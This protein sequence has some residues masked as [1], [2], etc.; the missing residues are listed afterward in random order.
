MESLTDPRAATAWL[1]TP[2]AIRARCRMVYEAAEAG[3]LRHFA[4][5]A[6]R[7]GEAARY[8][9]ETIRG[10]YPALDVPYHSRWRH[11]AVDGRDRWQELQHRLTGTP[12]DELARTRFDLA[13]TSVLLDAGAGA[14]WRYR[15]PGSGALHARSEG[16]ALASLYG[17]QDGLFSTDPERRCRADADAL[18][19]LE[20]ETL[21]SAFQADSGNPLIGL[22]GRAA[23]LR[24]LGGA[25]RDRPDLFGAERPRIGV[26]FDFF[27]A[28][29]G[30][31]GLP[32]ASILD[33]LLEAL[34]PI[35]PGRLAIDGA[36]LGD[37]WRHPAAAS[38]DL[39]DRLVPFH[40]L[41][42]WLAYSLVEPLEAA[43]VTVTGLDDLTGLAEYRNGGLFLDLGVLRPKHDGVL[44]RRHAADSELVVEWRALT[45]VLLDRVAEQIRADLGLSAAELPL[46][47]VLEGGTWSAGRRIAREKRSDGRPP[48]A[49]ESDGTLF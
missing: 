47:R 13:V 30:E 9:L 16:L 32:A 38:S 31:G 12:P 34:G 49:V 36:V 44:G 37:V 10:R 15:E 8:V 28:A 48:I 40:K 33:T 6:G 29:S 45:V 22:A 26:L 2:A 14:Q 35:W 43:G 23:L 25:L 42:Q 24:R 3:A 41:S 18:E 1:R 27:K 17:F 5:D 19:Q 20:T 21:A 39:T 7:L 4:L 11:F 46:A